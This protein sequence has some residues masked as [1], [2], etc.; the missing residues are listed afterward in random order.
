MKIL[1]KGAAAL[2]QATDGRITT[3]YYPNGVQGDERDVIRKMRLGQL[4]G[5][6]VTSVGLSLVYEGIRVLELPRMFASIEEMDYVRKKVWP[7]FRKKFAAKGF[8]LGEPGDVGWIHFFSKARVDKLS[9]LRKAKVWLWTDDPLAKAMF[10]KLNINAVP[11]GVPDVLP[12]LTSGRINA[13]YNSPLGAVALQWSSKV[14]YMTAMRMSYAQ[15]ATIFRKE[16]WLKASK[17]D[18]KIVTKQLRLQSAQ[19][20]KTVR[21]DNRTAKRQM[22]RKGVQAVPTSPELE[23]DFDRAAQQVWQG[24]VGKVYSQ[25]ELDMVMKYRDEY[26]A[27]NQ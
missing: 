11:M 9:D 12:S 8:V 25:A 1:D 3:K 5:A 18:R 7:Y 14:K 21:R 26:R 20:R 17:D 10:D 16:V 27:K 22:T 24:L 6:A 13:A 15:G 23:R 19:L 4:D 2:E